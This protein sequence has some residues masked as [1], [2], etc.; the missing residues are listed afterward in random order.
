MSDSALDAYLDRQDR[1]H[2]EHVALKADK[3]R[4]QIDLIRTLAINVKIKADEIL[5]ELEQLEQDMANG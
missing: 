5:Q 1:E 4:R 3:Q 2:E